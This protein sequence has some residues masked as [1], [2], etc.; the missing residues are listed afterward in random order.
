MKN[1]EIRKVITGAD[2]DTT[3]DPATNRAVTAVVAKWTDVTVRV[4]HGFDWMKPD[5]ANALFK[6]MRQA[7]EL[8]DES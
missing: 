4:E 5:D 8:N 3:F 6:K 2:T 7:C 1:F